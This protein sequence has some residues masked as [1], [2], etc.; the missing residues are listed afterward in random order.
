MAAVE[1]CIAPFFLTALLKRHRGRILH[2]TRKAERPEGGRM[3]Q[4]QDTKNNVPMT[5]G[6]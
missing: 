3:D 1:Q 2:L 4:G 5:V 6:L